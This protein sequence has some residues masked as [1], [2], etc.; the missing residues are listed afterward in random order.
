MHRLRTLGWSSG[1][2]LVQLTLAATASADE[3]KPTTAA[4]A[5][6]TTPS[7]PLAAA[8]AKDKQLVVHVL[9]PLCAN[10]QI[11]CGAAWAGKPGDLDK[12]L[13]WGAIFGVRTWME[14]PRSDWERLTVKGPEPLAASE[15]AGLEKKGAP[16]LDRRVYRRWVKGAPFGLGP[17]ERVEEIVVFDAIHGERIDDAVRQF[18]REATEGGTVSFSAVEKGQ[19][20]TRTVQVQVQVQV[21]VAGYAGHNRMLDGLT[22]PTLPASTPRSPG[23]KAVAARTPIPSFV[24][25]CLSDRTFGSPLRAAGSP[26]VL[27]TTALVAPEAYL[28]DAVLHALGE[29]KGGPGIREAAI[30]TYVK[31]QKLSHGTAAAMF[32]T[33][34]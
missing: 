9:V 7:S 3:N 30:Q 1:L 21:D 12:N 23:E 18:F 24:L 32:R 17:D 19:T 6:V 28:I 34:L 14:R 33:D 16:R 11:D 2:V 25:A 8:V 13:Y 22:L 15:A 4:P 20:S 10:D 5:A 29:G 27:D 31:W 26:I